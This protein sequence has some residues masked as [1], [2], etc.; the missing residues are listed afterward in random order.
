M[1][2]LQIFTKENKIAEN[3]RDRAEKELQ[4]V[5]SPFPE[6]DRNKQ[7]DY[8]IFTCPETNTIPIFGFWLITHGQ[9][10]ENTNVWECI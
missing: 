4:Q 1:S 3:F 6:V 7:S 5:S 8:T 2:Q 9:W 10:G